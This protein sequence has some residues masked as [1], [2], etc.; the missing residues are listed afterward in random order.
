MT[1][2]ACHQLLQGSRR[3]H[4]HAF[5]TAQFDHAVFTAI[6]DADLAVFDKHARRV[7]H[8]TVEMVEAVAPGFHV[9]I[10][11]RIE[12]ILPKEPEVLRLG[13]GDVVAEIP[14]NVRG[15]TR[16]PAANTGSG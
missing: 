7:Q 6:L 1:A 14:Q 13:T 15:R 3:F 5:G 2:P 8:F 16:L 9:I 10:R 12:E 11:R 4:G